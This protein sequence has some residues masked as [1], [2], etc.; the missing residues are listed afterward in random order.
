MAAKETSTQS[1][2]TFRPPRPERFC[3]IFNR[4]KYANWD[5]PTTITSVIGQAVVVTTQANIA[6]IYPETKSLSVPE[7]KPMLSREPSVLLLVVH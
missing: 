5:V 3:A 6:P 4:V 7:V 1:F 2:G